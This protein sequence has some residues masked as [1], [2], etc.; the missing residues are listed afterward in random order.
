MEAAPLAMADEPSPASLEKLPRINPQRTA[1]AAP[2][3]TTPPPA[4]RRPN[5]PRRML[6][7]AA[8]RADAWVRMTRAVPAR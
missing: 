3:P 7:R 1:A 6:S 8:G 5:A 2:Q 4:A